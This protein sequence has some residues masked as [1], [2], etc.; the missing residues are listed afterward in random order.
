MDFGQIIAQ[1]KD[2]IIQR[3]IERVR[4]DNAIT[5]I[6][7]LTY[8]GVLNSLPK[9]VGAI[10]QL[11]SQSQPQPFSSE[12]LRNLGIDHGELRAAQGYDAEEIFREYGIL[13]AVIFEQIEAALLQSEPPTL[14]RT[15]RLIDSALDSVITLCFQRYT[16]ERLREINL[17][18]DEMLASNQEL[19][20]LVRNEQKN[21]AHLAHELKNPLSCII[22]YSDL[23]LRKQGESG[24]LKLNFIEQVLSS[25]RRLLSVIN[26]TLE[27]SSYQAGK[28]AIS[29]E[30]V[31][32]CDLVEEVTT[33]IS[34]LAQ[35]KGLS[36]QTDCPLTEQQILT[37]RARLR[38]IVTN[39]VSNAVRYTESGT[40][41]VS[42]T[43]LD[44]A[45][46]IT[47]AD[48]GLGIDAG[49][50]AKIFEPFYQGQAEQQLPCSTGLGL[51][52][53]QQ[54]T[55]LLQGEIHLKSKPNIGSTFTVTLPLRY[56]QQPDDQPDKVSLSA[57]SA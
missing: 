8:K 25:G 18:Y 34:L 32:V 10:A 4:Q 6:R 7:E 43:P 37:D 57:S 15:I 31:N 55:T 41:S 56:E 33:V 21:I 23:F 46:E 26:E 1:R 44:S 14:L 29:L 16:E 49:E 17:L 3:W 27:M 30:L 51:A 39:L 12:N 20:R 19:D 40:I 2:D 45:T 22:G 48:T 47:V 11:L 13:R 35:Q 38:Q 28:I 5:S 36:I 53:A 50:Q 54:M 9:L 24:E 52:I 42:V